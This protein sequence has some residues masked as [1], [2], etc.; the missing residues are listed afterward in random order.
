MSS[1]VHHT[2]EYSGGSR[3]RPRRKW[4]GGRVRGI[5]RSPLAAGMQRT[6]NATAATMG[7]LAFRRSANRQGDR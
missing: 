6:V 3:H 1:R 7:A 4:S 5:P 2:T